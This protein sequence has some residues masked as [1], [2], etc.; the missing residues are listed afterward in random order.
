[1]LVKSNSKALLLNNCS[2]SPFIFTAKSSA[3]M[4]YKSASRSTKW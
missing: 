2:G 3:D 1:L 4:F